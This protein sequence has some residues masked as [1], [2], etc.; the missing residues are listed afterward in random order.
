[1]AGSKKKY[2]AEE[3]GPAPGIFAPWFGPGMAEETTNEVVKS[4]LDGGINW[5]DTAEAYGNGRSERA[6]AKALKAAGIRNGDVIVA[7]K[8]MPQMRTADSIRTTIKTRLSCLGGFD[9]DLQYCP[10][11]YTPGDGSHK[12]L[13][14]AFIGN[15]HIDRI[16]RG[17]QH[18]DIEGKGALASLRAFLAL[19]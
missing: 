6:L 9:I 17:I 2:Y 19:C 18:R 4:A 3:R 14:I 16:H 13:G 8:R 15:L 7:T 12:R 10:I 5:F 11:L 1:M